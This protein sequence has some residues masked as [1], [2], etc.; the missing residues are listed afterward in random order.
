MSTISSNKTVLGN[1]IT[2]NAAAAGGSGD[3]TYAV[4]YKKTSDANW[5]TKQKFTDN[6]E[7]VIKP[8]YATTYDVM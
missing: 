4:Y 2:V 6:T 5:T 1:T 3:Y 8:A 7:V